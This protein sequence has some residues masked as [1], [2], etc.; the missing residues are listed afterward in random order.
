MKP[1]RPAVWLL[2]WLLD[3]ASAEAIVGDL[4]EEFRSVAAQCGRAAG[5]RWFW[6]QTLLSITSRRY[7]LLQ[8]SW[9]RAG[10]NLR[11]AKI[12]DGLRQDVRFTIRLLART[13]AFA[14]VAIL[15]L[16]LGIGAA[17]AIATAANRAL[18]RPL[19]Y[20]HGDRLVFTGH[21]DDDGSGAVGN[22]GF[23]TVVD[24]RARL[25]TF[26]ELAI[27]RG[28]SP[29]LVA[30]GGAE[31]LDGMKVNWNYFRMLGVQPALGRDFTAEEDQP[32]RW[33]VVLLSDGLWRRRFGAR[34]DIVGST[35]E[36]NGRR[37]EVAGVLPA[38]F[39]PVV[40]EHFYT[41]AEVWAPLGYGPADS[42]ACRSCQHL[43]LI[44]R[45]RPGAT[46]DEARAELASVHAGLKRE[47]PSDYTE[48]SPAARMLHDEITGP[49][50]RPLQVLL[51]A[52]GFVLLVG[53]ANVAGLL[54]ARAIDRERELVVRAA[55]G[56]GRGRLVRQ[57]LTESLVLATASAILGVLVARWGLGLLARHAPIAVPR[58]DH[59]ATDPAVL[60]IGAAVTAAALMAF[61]LVPAWTSARLDLQSVLSE[62]RHPSGR[63]AL[64]T[65]E[66][67]IA[68][69]VAAALV[70]LAA[71][72]LMFR[73][74]DRLLHV[75]PGFDPRGV[76]SVG[77]SL[78]GPP[79]AEDDAVRAF[80][81]E[82]LRRISGLPGVE[83]A[84]LAG[85]IPLGDNY[86]RRGFRIE[87]RT[88]VSDAD[89]PSVERYGV[90]PDYFAVMRI[91]LRKGRLLSDADK[92]DS[93]LVMLV[94]DTAARTLWPGQDPLGSR[95]RI[96]GPAAPW[97][98]VVGVVGDVRHYQLGDPPTPQMYVP[99]QQITDSFL[100]LVVR[101]FGEPTNLVP[102][103][104]RE[105]RAIAR[106]VPVYDIAT[107]E[108]RVSASVASRRFLMLLLS[109][110]A[111]ATLVMV[112]VGLYGAV[113]QA[114][115]SRRRELGIRL[116]LGATR[117]HIVRLVLGR[118]LTLVGLGIAGGL[119]ASAALEEVLRSQ[120]YETPAGDPVALGL[121]VASLTVVALIAHLIP[122][123]RAIGV[124]PSLTLRSD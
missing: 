93:Q 40:S 56:A 96:G 43:K 83:R 117:R 36:F 13:P 71:A 17:T 39:E 104:R 48:A 78:V 74:V 19:P 119:A 42:S 9:Q 21:P 12:M 3:R 106:D 20:P 37:F 90:T 111:T 98:T 97:R 79:W 75:D 26:D 15:T 46:L 72:G 118:G 4:V 25:R 64:R 33:R 31:R 59:A 51:F 30:E 70:L 16:A 103:I 32:E 63:R 29:T 24:W 22:V 80:Q 88:Y 45:L 28:W 92:S 99:Q 44:G 76:L 101:A 2:E 52:V 34:P 55:L 89:A 100:V 102:A 65:R 107:L 23:A 67:L 87:G 8:Q 47:H 38:S 112:A 41:R 66:L 108:V 49:L 6:R 58:L 91:P 14:T 73:T 18:L 116:A 122:L 1:P 7:S 57:L 84:A 50:R 60:L 115:S 82:L 69:E 27:I 77:L 85:Q 109:V 53:C 54:V 86:D 11:K 81:R 123:R 105:V 124:N 10:D 62:T 110:F 114:V 68:G 113:S 35:I 94:N 121:S 5:R 95:V 61:G 120:L